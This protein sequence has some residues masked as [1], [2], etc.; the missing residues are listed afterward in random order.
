MDHE[1]AMMQ[2]DRPRMRCSGPRVLAGRA[3]SRQPAEGT[4][5]AGRSDAGNC[6]EAWRYVSGHVPVG[7]EE[8]PADELPCD[9]LA[10]NVEKTF[11]R[12]PPPHCSH[13]CRAL[14]S[15]FSRN[16]VTCPHL[17]HRYSNNGIVVLP[18]VSSETP[19]R[20]GALLPDGSHRYISRGATSILR[21]RD[22]LLQSLGGCMRLMRSSLPMASSR[23]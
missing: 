6:P 12:F 23:R 10:L 3:H 16:S 21:G 2:H 14:L 7:Q 15:A 1:C 22:V 8:P 17:V 20:V 5:L 4:A 18:S 11:S 9:A 13:A 19:P